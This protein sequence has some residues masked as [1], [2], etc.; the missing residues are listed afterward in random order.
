MASKLVRFPD[1]TLV[2]GS[3][4]SERDTG[5]DQREFGLYLDAR[6]QPTWPA[7]LIEWPDFGTP[8]ADDEAAQAIHRTFQRAR[9]G[10]RVEVGCAGGRGRTG[11]VLACMAVLSGVP[12]DEAL[13]WIRRHYAPGA[14]ETA[15]QEAWIG[16]FA[17]LASRRGWAETSRSEHHRGGDAPNGRG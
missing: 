12:G 4:L 2:R 7:E 5:N 3:P 6:W 11:T 13:I 1:G 8:L 9:A 10:V 17:T 16:W 15:A 14:V